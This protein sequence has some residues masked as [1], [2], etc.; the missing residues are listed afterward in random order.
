ML[1][2][3]FGLFLFVAMSVSCDTLGE[4]PPTWANAAIQERGVHG[5]LLGETT[6]EEVEA[7]WGH[8]GEGGGWW[9]GAGGGGLSMRLNSGQVGGLT[10]YF[11]DTPEGA[12][13]S[14][15]AYQFNIIAPYKGRTEAGIGVGSSVAE[16]F[17]AYGPPLHKRSTGHYV[18]GGDTAAVYATY[19]AY[20]YCMGRSHFSL[21]HWADADTINSVGL[22]SWVPPELG[23]CP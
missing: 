3:S 2:Q 1:R 10:V 21:G 8:L 7:Q 11:V 13:R 6:L 9:G 5:I 23:T 4:Q 12:F 20:S 22:G 19:H 18:S 17:A 15:K 14:G 16:V